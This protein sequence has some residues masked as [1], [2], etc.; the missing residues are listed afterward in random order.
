LPA[1]AAEKRIPLWLL[2]IAVQF[3]E[4]S[5]EHF[6]SAGDRESAHRARLYSIER[7]RPVLHAVHAQPRVYCAGSALAY[8]I[9]QLIPR[10]RGQR[11][12]LIVCCGSVLALILDL[13]VHRPDL[14]LYDS[15]GRWVLVYGITVEQHLFWRWP[16]CSAAQRFSIGTAMHKARLIGFV[17]FLAAFRCLGR[18]FFP[19]PLVTMRLRSQPWVPMLSWRPWPGG[20]TGVR[21]LSEANRWNGSPGKYFDHHDFGLQQISESSTCVPSS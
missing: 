11:T 2:F 16:F 21:Q 20:W 4:R 7:S 12:G 10:L 9:C 18:S 3:I 1:R 5:V 8:I 17:I 15:V 13:I 14:A 19:P 6:R